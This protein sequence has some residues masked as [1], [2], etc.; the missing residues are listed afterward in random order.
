MHER[1]AEERLCEQDSVAVT[2]LC[3]PGQRALEGRTFFCVTEDLSSHGLRLRT[4][5]PL[6]GGSV[7]ELRVAFAHPLR[8]LKHHARVVWSSA[9]SDG[10]QFALGIEFAPDHPVESAPWRNMVRQRMRKAYAAPVGV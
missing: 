4:D 3:A 10:L 8:A 1:R 5:M 7:L 2:V 6:P 9:S